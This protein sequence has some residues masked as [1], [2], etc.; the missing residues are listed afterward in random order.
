ML[1]K[2]KKIK[3]KNSGIFPSLCLLVVVYGKLTVYP[4]ISAFWHNCSFAVKP[5]WVRTIVILKVSFLSYIIKGGGGVVS[6][7][8]E[9]RT[10]FT[11]QTSA[12]DPLDS[13]Y[14]AYFDIFHQLS[15]LRVKNLQQKVP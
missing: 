7:K 14:I 9:K 8:S 12:I 2:K 6:E 11:R 3:I 10:E 13:N 1:I 5:T 4:D 15:H